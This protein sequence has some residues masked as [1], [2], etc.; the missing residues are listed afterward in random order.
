MLVVLAAWFSISAGGAR[1]AMPA[2]DTIIANQA[3]ADMLVPG[4]SDYL[5]V[6]SNRV[7]LRVG[8]IEALTLDADG[9]RLVAPGAQAHFAHTLVNTGNTASTYVF[10]IATKG[11]GTASLSGFRLFLDRDGDGVVGAGDTEIELDSPVLSLEAGESAHVIV[12]TLMQAGVDDGAEGS[13]VLTAT[14]VL[15]G[16]MARNTDTAVVHAGANFSVAKAADAS[17]VSSGDVITYRLVASNISSVDGEPLTEVEEGGARR[18]I[19]IDGAAATVVLLRDAIPANTVFA[20]GTLSGIGAGAQLL[21]R[22]AGDPAFTYRT[23]EAAHIVEVAVAVPAV[24]AGAQLGMSFG[25]RVD[26]MFSGRVDN[27]GRIYFDTGSDVGRRGI[28]SNL[29]PV[30]VTA[31]RGPDLRIAK[32]H[33]GNF[34]AGIEQLYTIS[35]SSLGRPTSGTVTVVDTL[36]GGMSFA[37]VEGTDW[38][39]GVAN[40]SGGQVVTCTTEQ[41]IGTDA[42]ATPIRL[43]VRVPESSLGGAGT[44]EFTNVAQVSGGGEPPELSG[45]NEA[46]DATTVTAPAAISGRV[47]FDSNHDRRHQTEEGGL[48]GWRVQLLVPTGAEAPAGARA[49]PAPAGMTVMDETVTAGDGSYGF[50]V[51]RARAD[52]AVR[53]L[54]PDGYLYGTPVDGESGTAISGAV[55]DPDRATLRSIAV[56]PGQDVP[57]QSLPVN[58]TGLVYDS[59]SRLAVAGAEI[60]VEGPAG[61]DPATHLVGGLANLVQTTGDDGY[62][63]FLLTSTAPAGTYTLKLTV[64]TGY[65]SESTTIPP[66]DGSLAVPDGEMPMAIQ[67]QP[68]A[69]SAGASTTYYMSFVASADSRPVVNNHIPLERGASADALVLLSKAASKSVV[70]TVDLV[71]YRLALANRSGG[72]LAGVVFID[73]PATGFTYQ[74]GSARLTV[75][76]APAT[77]VE[78]TLV[79]NGHGGNDL[80]FDL[81]SLTVAAD[82]VVGLTYRMQ[83]N[84]T[85]LSGDGINRASASAGGIPSNPA[86][87]KVK[88][89]GGAFSDEGFIIGKVFLDCNENGV[90]DEGAQAAEIGVPGVRIYL[91]DGSFVVTDVEGKYSLYGVRPMTH[92]LK[93]D[94]TTLPDGALLGGVG[95]RNSDRGAS[96]ALMRHQRAM[97]RFVD[98]KKGELHKANFAVTTCGDDIRQ[99]IAGRRK[100]VEASGDEGAALVRRDFEAE[101]TP[102]TDGDYRGRPQSGWIDRA[103][104]QP[105]AEAQRP[106]DS[107]ASVSGGVPVVASAPLEELMARTD[108]GLAFLNLREGQVLPIAQASVMVKGALGARFVLEVNGRRIDEGRV[109]KRSAAATVGAE[110]WEFV[111]VTFDP[112]ENVVSLAQYDG[113]DNERGRVTIK[114]TAPGKLERIDATVPEKPIADGATPATIR[115]RLSD[116]RGV[117]F[118]PRTQVTI[119]TDIGSLLVDD[120]A[121]AEPGVQVFVNGGMGEV[122]IRPPTGPGEGYLTIAA[123]TLRQRF[124]IRFA[125][126]LRPML[127]VGLAEGVVSLSKL[128]FDG[129]EPV[130]AGDAFERE[131]TAYSADFG[132]GKG[133][134]AGRAAFF[135]KGRIRGDYLLTAAYDS[136]RKVRDRLFRDIQPDEYYPVY[137]DSSERGFDAQ[138]SG[139]LFVRVDK[140]ES[141]VV[142]GDLTTESPDEI[143]KI[144][145]YSR[146][147]TGVKGHGETDVAGLPIE[148]TGF[149]AH[150][151]LRQMVEEFRANGTSGPFTLRYPD[152]VGDTEQVTVITRD[153]SQ[154]ALV[155]KVETK[156]RFVDYEIDELSGR[157]LFKAPIPSLDPDLNP[158]SIRIVYEVDTGGPSFWLY[159]V[160]A[161]VKPVDGME[162]GGLYIRDEDPDQSFTMQ[163]AFGRYRF[164]DVT[165]LTAEYGHT[166]SGASLVDSVVSEAGRPYGNL[167]DAHQGDGARIAFR[168]DGKDV[169]VDIEFQTSDIGFDNPSATVSAGRS[170]LTAKADWQAEQDLSFGL[171]GRRSEDRTNGGLRE[172]VSIGAE[173]RFDNDLR[174]EVGMRRYRETLVAAAADTA[175][176]TPYNGTTAFGKLTATLPSDP[177]LLGYLEYEQDILDADH[178][179]AAV[180]SEYQVTSWGKAYGRYEF[181][182]SLGSL[183]SLNSDQKRYVALAGFDL[184]YMANGSAYSEYRMADAL[185]GRAAQAALGLRNTFAISEDWRLGTTIERVEPIN[186]PKSTLADGYFYGGDYSALDEES[187]A[188]TLALEYVGDGDVKGAGR[189]EARRSETIDTFLNTVAVA[190]KLDEDWTLLA[191]NGIQLD[192]GRA[193]GGGDATR[194]REQI[195]FA[196][197]PVAHDD[198]NLLA[199]YEHRFEELKAAAATLGTTT[200]ATFIDGDSRSRAHVVS[201]HTNWQLAPTLILSNRYALKYAQERANDVDSHTWAQLLYGRLTWDVTEDWDA[202]LQL[203]GLMGEGGT[204]E[205]GLGVEVGYLMADS[206]WL[207]LGYNVTGFR[208]SDLAGEEPTDQGVYV[209]FRFKFD[210]SLF[211][212]EMGQ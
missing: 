75:G 3:S 67:P 208:D 170:E 150:D 156:V 183:Y 127:A 116:S 57:E 175:G 152:F 161:R 112:G 66:E 123:G 50:T 17:S 49:A 139:R 103:S 4:R 99:D 13:L 78:P 104:G 8:A 137:G 193:D 186:S 89:V 6:Y 111:G 135:L 153:R 71:D 189:I 128:D 163:G 162:L 124:P 62:Y 43:T 173:Y 12:E 65:E 79:P 108:A 18:D 45:D 117:P 86:S 16:L 141:Y 114:V 105:A 202:G 24:A 131:L 197:R 35:V 169:R 126:A 125:P 58:P 115:I 147:L 97:T 25:V 158:Q 188:G 87:A 11:G 37:G 51:A 81:A 54:S 118:T 69:P 90:Q 33:A 133:A 42:P 207:S 10:S 64:P 154:P 38:S 55:L 210:E 1:A 73:K 27:S 143:R 177:N 107:A 195:G 167:L 7:E 142:Y 14:T 179:L 203:F 176:V 146:S 85:A 204:Y 100:L 5:T 130:R 198:F 148:I 140:D 201:A 76:T 187:T 96:E 80:R 136:E 144:T 145:Q 119:D 174:G 157:L 39:C 209:R 106:A 9:R 74:P 28:D 181:I 63:Q 59:A 60:T 98:L 72:P 36:P 46:R 178:Q 53:F 190:W 160:D 22:A 2:V 212:G 109:G 155:I 192:R 30:T 184:S 82:E 132:A 129:M 110:G 31:G 138:S 121:P 95:N 83:V 151:N 21:W 191:R 44:A 205:T 149:A 199:R 211:G 194:Y 48:P 165:T 102:D 172:G 88:V 182:S 122:R 47:W 23:V 159:G 70:E 91:E 196:Y 166:R 206:L 101:S 92:V 113:F 200:G 68:T 26:D 164:T 29:V 180:G 171:E 41:V 134:V 93:L 120:L 40:P 34:V 168:H 185:S 56:D 19:I 20:T 15:Q 32:S 52:Y 84:A 94:G 77:P 61:F